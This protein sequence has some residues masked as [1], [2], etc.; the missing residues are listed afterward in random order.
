[1]IFE[2]LPVD[3]SPGFKVVECFIEH[4]GDILLLMW[5]NEAQ[6]DVVVL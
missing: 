5:N 3:Y 6:K 4:R 2:I 1:M